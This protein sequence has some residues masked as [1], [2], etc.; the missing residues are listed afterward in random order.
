M[1]LLFLLYAVLPIY[2]ARRSHSTRLTRR[3]GLLGILG[4]DTPPTT[5]ILDPVT[6]FPSSSSSIPTPTPDGGLLGD[7]T[8]AAGGLVSNVGGVVSTV[9][10][11]LGGAVSTV[12][13]DLGGII[14]GSPSSTPT[15]S[16][17][18]DVPTP[19][20]SDGGLLGGLTSVVGGVLDPPSPSTTASPPS[21]T[22]PAPTPTSS[23]DGGL[24]GGL[25]SVVGGVLDPPSPS[26]TAPPPSDTP[27]T[28]TSSSDGGLLGGVTSVVG[29]VISDV[30]G[31]VS[32]IGSDVGGVLNP[33]SP[34]TTPPTPPSSPSQT[35]PPTP[36]SSSDGGL[37]GGVTSIV[38]GLTSDVGGIISTVTSGL[39]GVVGTPTSAPVNT[40]PIS[41]P[42]SS[43]GGIIDTLTSGIGGVITTV[44][45]DL[46]GVIPTSISSVDPNPPVTD[47]P[48]GNATSTTT[49]GTVEPT[50][51]TSPNITSSAQPTI[52]FPTQT[53]NVSTSST[54]LSTTQTSTEIMTTV[55][56]T[57]STTLSVAS[58]LSFVL[59]E[60]TLAFASLPTTTPSVTFTDPDQATPAA[61][62]PVT[63]LVAPPL[64]SGIPGWIYPRQ[65]LNSSNSDLEGFTLISILF[66]KE[67]NWM[68]EIQDPISASQIFVYMPMLISTALRIPSDQVKTFALRVYIPDTY[69]SPNDAAQ[70]GTLYLGYI[71]SDLIDPLS[72]QI[73]VK[74]SAFYTQ[75][76]D[77]NSRALAQRV[78]PS[79]SLLSVSP[80][81]DPGSGGPSDDS[82]NNNG[83]SDS[84]KT[85]EEAIIGV[86]S[87]LGSIALLVLGFLVY[88]S[89]KRRQQLAHRRLSDPPGENLGVRPQGREFDQDSVGGARRRSF[90]YAE[91]S[92]RGYES[93]PAPNDQLMAESSMSQR[94]NVVPGSI[95]APVLRGSTMNW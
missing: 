26:T 71:P 48:S 95:S 80:N 67:L 33:P 11:D 13:S 40:T 82:G 94:R 37:L 43:S 41:N 66:N 28:P 24:L 39:G 63:T 7:L 20:S 45:S 61:P 69:H 78:V 52:S 36:T 60:S 19:S 27:P 65:R 46:G 47:G 18:S 77:D 10:S 68:F 62:Q 29:G 88:R 64:P 3:Q 56:T 31:A 42:G 8:S 93:Q 87:A 73:K 22:P 86:V 58:D 51:V 21:D 6:V 15:A 38:G 5:S 72:A 17:P 34:S 75:G 57:T 84:G 9:G 90:Y 55:T 53:T 74:S 50:D 16:P 83:S 79:Y 23:S 25:T 30:G 81:D 59:E 92:L 14:G 76:P 2:A 35:Q 49:S 44:T 54:T 12:G 91:D 32:T 70:L 4:P 85:R 1:R 89:Y